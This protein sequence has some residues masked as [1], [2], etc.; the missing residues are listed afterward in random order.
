M[1]SILSLLVVLTLSILVTR[2]ATVALTYTGLSRESAKF[3]ARSAFTGVGFTTN[4]SEKAVNH[5]IRRRILLLLMLLGNAGVITAVSSLIISFVNTKESG[6]LLWNVV[7]LVTGIITLWSLANSKWV[8]RHLSN[9]IAKFLKKNT[10]LNV[11][12]Y[13]NLLHL[14]G[15]YQISELHVQHSDWIANQ[16]L[17]ALKLREEGV[18]VL[19]IT[20][21][22]GDYVGVPDGRTKIQP[23][24]IL[25]SYGRAK[26]V[27][28]IDE[29]KVGSKGNREHKK[30]VEEQVRKKNKEKEKDEH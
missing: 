3:Q 6:S 25:I 29:R 13:A 16:T 5:P 28:E 2:I 21:E 19:G 12:D 23:G 18:V 24:D 11:Q 8:D 10:R 22:N 26:A 30:K 27:A 17:A 20:R 1:I 15:E 7:L 4:E 14:A 9:L